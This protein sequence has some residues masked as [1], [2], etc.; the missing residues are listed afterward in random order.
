MNYVAKGNP[1]FMILLPLPPKYWIIVI[2]CHAWHFPLFL[3][4]G[5]ETESYYVAQAG[6]EFP[7]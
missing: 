5:F 2:Y 6:F 3:F 1:K 4:F 7:M